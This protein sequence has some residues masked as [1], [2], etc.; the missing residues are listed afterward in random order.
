MD[1]YGRFVGN[2]R[3]AAGTFVNAEVIRAGYARVN[4]DLP[5]EDL[6]QFQ[7]LEQEARDAGR[8]R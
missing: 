1:R 4:T 6:E 8:G 2:V 7:Q 3:L 5:P